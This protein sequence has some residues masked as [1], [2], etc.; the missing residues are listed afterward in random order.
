MLANHTQK[1]HMAT[2]YSIPDDNCWQHHTWQLLLATPYPA[3]TAGN[4]I[5]DN[6][7]QHVTW[8]YKLLLA[9]PCSILPGKHHTWQLLATL[10]L[11]I[12]I[13]AGNTMFNTAGQKHTWQKPVWVW[14]GGQ[15]HTCSL[16]EVGCKVPCLLDSPLCKWTQL[17]K[18]QLSVHTGQCWE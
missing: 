14:Q 9:T 6:Y 7:W 8:W 3:K 2:P 18:C 12:Q 5:P 16:S 13:T 11:T 15:P 10:Y 1:L 4:T 17:Q